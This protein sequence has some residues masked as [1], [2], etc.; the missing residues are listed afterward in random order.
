MGVWIAVDAEMRARDL[1]V[2]I[3]SHT[4]AVDAG[5]VALLPSKRLKERILEEDSWWAFDDDLEDVEWADG[6]RVLQIVLRKAD[7][8]PWKCVFEP[9]VQA[10]LRKADQGP[11]K[12][13]FEPQVQAADE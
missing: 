6:G 13:D 4:L 3:K 5:S 2:D 1:N 9:Q 7:Q 8:G 10:V 12:G 11:W